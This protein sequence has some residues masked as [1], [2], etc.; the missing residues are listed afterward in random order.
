MASR[1]N[2]LTRIIH[3]ERQLITPETKG[4]AFPTY[5]GEITA[6]IYEKTVTVKADKRGRMGYYLNGKRL[7]LDKFLN[8]LE[9]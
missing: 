2:T 1:M 7:S 5:A 4:F 3:L 9:G 8:E 6:I